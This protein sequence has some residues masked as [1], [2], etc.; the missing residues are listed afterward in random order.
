MQITPARLASTAIV[1]LA[2]TGC[3]QPLGPGQ[4]ATALSG[5]PTSRACVPNLPPFGYWQYPGERLPM[6]YAPP[7]GTILLGDDGGWCQIRF[8]HF[9]G[10]R[11]IQAPL[12]VT[13]PP[14]HGETLVGSV[15]TSL[16]IAYRPANGF[17][18]QDAFSVHLTA[19][20]PFD[21]PVHVIVVR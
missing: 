14:A 3:Q 21:I 2:L 4:N 12:A 15:G 20:Q 16:R 9:W 6:V 5:L 18:G 1:L 7:N 11:P 17:A 8:E 19:P 10:D 13:T